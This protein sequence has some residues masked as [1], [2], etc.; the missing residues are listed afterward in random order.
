MIFEGQ[1]IVANRFAEGAHRICWLGPDEWLI[2]AELDSAQALVAQLTEALA[3][4]LYALRRP[5]GR[6]A[7]RAADTSRIDVTLDKG[8]GG[9]AI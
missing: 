6:P 5:L 9:I 1:Q 4:R 8:T 3:D 2:V 7:C